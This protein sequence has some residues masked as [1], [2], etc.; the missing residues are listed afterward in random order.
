MM[1]TCHSH[2][3]GIDVS[4]DELEIC[5]INQSKR[6]FVQIPN[7]KKAILCWLK[8][9]DK[10]RSYCVLEYTGT[11]SSQLLHLLGRQAIEVSVVNPNQSSHFIKALGI[12]NKND[13]NAAEAL[14]LMGSSLDL[15]WYVME[16]SSRQK[17]KQV[18][19]SLSALKK[20][21]QML[22]NQ[23]HALSF[24][25]IVNSAVKQ[26]FETTLQTVSEQIQL[27]EEEL[28]SLSDEEHEKQ[29]N[30]ITSVV[31]I[32][33]KTAQALL[34]ATGGLEQFEHDRQLAKFIGIVPLS[35]DS[36]SSVRYRGPITK[37]GNA[38]LRACLYMA[39]RSA[40]RFNLACKELYERLRSRGKCH[41][42]AMVAVMNKLVRQVFAVVKH[43]RIF[44]NQYY[45]KYK[46]A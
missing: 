43:D 9:L 37:K 12:V 15:P 2:V 38:E 6:S 20:Q 24:Q 46:S 5:L 22:K 10:K 41:R 7:T 35:H 31:G 23:L 44:D 17:R 18:L 25:A 1:S 34:T 26:A 21:R 4:K 32:G 28:D 36:G 40:R 14:A 13:K 16:P 29:L 8:E 27:L 30:K 19:S 39:A 33:P 3:Y 42:Q 11:Y 45:L